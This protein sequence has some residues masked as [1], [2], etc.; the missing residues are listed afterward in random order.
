MSLK[1]AFEQ[2]IDRCPTDQDIQRLFKVK[3][4]LGLD[5][6]DAIWTVLLALEYYRTL[7]EEIPDQIQRATQIVARNATEQA[8]SQIVQ[9]VSNLIPHIEE[10]VAKTA[11]DA[12][13]R[14]Q[15]GRTMLSIWASGVFLWL[16][17]VFGYMLG[18]QIFTTYQVTSSLLGWDKLIRITA[19]SMGLSFCA[20]SCIA[21]GLWCRSMRYTLMQY[22]LYATGVLG[23]GLLIY[24]GHM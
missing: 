16:A 15:A 11:G 8:Q 9:A 22:L 6:N 12:I 5:S 10:A 20:T 19:L 13:K 23:Y 17:M 2:L 7:Y 18:S 21:L 4:A 24:I 14:V 1:S 3:E